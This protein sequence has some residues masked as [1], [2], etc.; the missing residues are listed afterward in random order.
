MKYQP[1]GKEGLHYYDRLKLAFR[2]YLELILDYGIMYY[3]L[4]GFNMW[5]NIY[6][7]SEFNS[8]LEAIYFSAS[9]ITTL[10]Y[11][12]FAPISFVSQMFCSYEVINGFTLIVVSFTVY[13]NLNFKKNNP[14][15]YRSKKE[16]S[17]RKLSIGKVIIFLLFL[18]IIVLGFFH[19]SNYINKINIQKTNSISKMANEMELIANELKEK[20]TNYNIIIKNLKEELKNSKQKYNKIENKLNVKMNKINK[21][22]KELQK[23]KSELQRLKKQ[24]YDIDFD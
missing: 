8:I 14:Y 2:S 20:E 22:D 15:K 23:I 17:A 24:L 7:D 10:G 21:Y 5:E 6:F 3:I 1:V 16:K 4:S 18:F 13:V 12:D 19:Q 11:G 9:T